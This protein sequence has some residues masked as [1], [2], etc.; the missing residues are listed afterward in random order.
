MGNMAW[1]P[2]QTGSVPEHFSAG[3]GL[4]NL[5]GSVAPRAHKLHRSN[6]EQEENEKM[7]ERRQARIFYDFPMAVYKMGGL[8]K[9]VQN[10]DEL[11]AAK[12][13]GWY[14]DVRDVPTLEPLEAPTHVSQMT[15]TQAAAFLAEHAQDAAKLAEIEADEASHGNRAQVLALINEAKD[16][17]G[18]KAKPAQPDPVKAKKK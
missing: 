15:V 14:A 18:A 1:D 9:D 5:P 3:G 13:K 16:N 10:A 4:Q 6:I 7:A 2:N 17:F 12:E 8:T 11:E